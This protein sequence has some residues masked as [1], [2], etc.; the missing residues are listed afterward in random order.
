MNGVTFNINGNYLNTILTYNLPINLFMIYLVFMPIYIFTF[1]YVL[2]SEAF[3]AKV[4]KLPLGKY[5]HYILDKLINA[6]KYS[7]IFWIYLILFFLLIFTSSSSYA[8]YGCL[9]ILNH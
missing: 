2:D 9:F 1:K 4:Q 5:L 3:L 7:S 8:I 6:W